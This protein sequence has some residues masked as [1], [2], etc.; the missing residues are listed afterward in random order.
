MAG[1]RDPRRGAI[2]V[3]LGLAFPIIFVIILAGI[4]M[5]RALITRHRLEHAVSYATRFSA[6][7]N[8][9][10]QAQV[11]AMVRDRM[12][13]TVD[14]CSNLAI[15]VTVV[16]ATADGAPQALQVDATC[17]LNQMFADWLGVPQVSSVAAMPLPL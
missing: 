13:Q 5:G 16:P 6:V 3:E 9:T 11:S 10:G 7:A 1:R 4:Q 8:Q 2:A 14:Q 15:D 12:G 17:T